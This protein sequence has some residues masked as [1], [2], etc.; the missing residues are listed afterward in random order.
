MRGDGKP[1]VGGLCGQR[2]HGEVFA[3][4]QVADASLNQT[5]HGFIGDQAGTQHEHQA[6]SDHQP[7]GAF[8][9]WSGMGEGNAGSFLV[10]RAEDPLA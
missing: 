5:V 6:E 4:S 8:Y 9:R 10:H 3:A 2:I 7:V 1:E